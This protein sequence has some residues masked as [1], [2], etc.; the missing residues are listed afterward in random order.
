MEDWDSFKR[1]REG[2]NT[3]KETLKR[4]TI[5]NT[6][7]KWKCPEN[8]QWDNA[9]LLLRKTAIVPNLCFP[10]ADLYTME[11]TNETA[12]GAGS[13]EFLLCFSNIYRRLWIHYNIFIESYQCV[14]TV[15]GQVFV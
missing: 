7:K 4:L 5:P 11:W 10:G 1:K 14:T 8:Y 6:T 9:Q 2:L 13:D 12:F 15:I 3:D